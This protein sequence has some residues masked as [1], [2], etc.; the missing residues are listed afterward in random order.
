MAG[1]VAD[2]LKSE[3]AKPA[4]TGERVRHPPKDHAARWGLS[5]KSPPDVAELLARAN[6]LFQQGM[7][8]DAEQL[9]RQ[10]VDTSPNPFVA[11]NNRGVALER[12]DRL[13]EEPASIDSAPS[14]RAGCAAAFF[15]CGIGV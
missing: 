10:I 3:A 14:I 11:L 9:Y 6:G 1:E 5:L 15:T 2:R 8:A 12:L 13:D 7:L 4:R